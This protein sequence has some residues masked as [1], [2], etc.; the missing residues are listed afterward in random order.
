[1]V[2]TYFIKLFHFYVLGTCSA[3]IIPED[4]DSTFLRNV[5]IYLHVHT[6]L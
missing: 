4:S 6:E 5:G 3:D 2:T 1:M